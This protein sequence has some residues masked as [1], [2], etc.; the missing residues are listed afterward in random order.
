MSRKIGKVPVTST[1]Q[2]WWES[3]LSDL[4]DDPEGITII[5]AVLENG[6]LYLICSYEEEP[7]NRIEA[8][9][10]QLQ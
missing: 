10:N 7:E 9:Q 3:D 1:F 6:T 8:L 2:E 5:S 4:F